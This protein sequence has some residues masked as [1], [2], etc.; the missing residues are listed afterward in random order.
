MSYLVKSINYCPVK[1]LSF[2]SIKSLGSETSGGAQV[3]RVRFKKKFRYN[4]KKSTK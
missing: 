1:S 4:K 2:Q 3:P